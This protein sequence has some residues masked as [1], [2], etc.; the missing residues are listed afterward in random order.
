M[1]QASF[2]SI[3]LR[4]LLVTTPLAG[5]TSGCIG[6]SSC[7]GDDDHTQVFTLDAAGDGS[8]SNDGVPDGGVTTFNCADICRE[9]VGAGN[10]ITY[11]SPT[12]DENGNDAVSCTFTVIC[13]G[14]RP[15]G[16]AS[17]PPSSAAN[18]VGRFFARVSHN[19]AASV[20]AFRVLRDELR[21]HSAPRTLV[22]ASIRSARDEVRHARMTAALAKRYG[23]AAERPTVAPRPIRPLA[24]IAAENAAEGCVRETYG[25]LV[26]TWQARAAADPVV[27]AVMR[28]IARDEA[29]HAALGWKVA[30]WAEARLDHTS[31]ARVAEAR[32]EAWRA[33]TDAAAQAVPESLVRHAGLPRSAHALAM[34][35]ELAR[36]LSARLPD[37]LRAAPIVLAR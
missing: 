37:S 36:S 25:A 11:C 33:I 21:A 17:R 30:R 28:R 23:A 24:D 1:K 19:E 15:A 4:I 2:E 3:L 6:T 34:L 8:T 31:R 20:D 16:L 32:A 13:E 9:R 27:R 22:R 29:R 18:E 26:A 10:N 7:D 35:D 14:R 12:K 5:L